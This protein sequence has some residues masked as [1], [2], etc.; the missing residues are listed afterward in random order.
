M[1]PLRFLPPWMVTSDMVVQS[2]LQRNGNYKCHGS[3]FK[4]WGSLT[5]PTCESEQVAFFLG[6]HTLG[7]LLGK[8][9]ELVENNAVVSWAGTLSF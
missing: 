4:Y 3:S 2:E 9:S 1:Y 8:G 6:V 7:V 5:F